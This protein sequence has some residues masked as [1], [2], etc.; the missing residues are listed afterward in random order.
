MFN[1]FMDASVTYKDRVVG[2][3]ES[4]SGLGLSTCLTS[5]MGHEKWLKFADKAEEGIVVIT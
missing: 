5:D 3:C 4:K 2:R 1:M